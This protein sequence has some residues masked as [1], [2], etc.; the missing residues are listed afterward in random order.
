MSVLLEIDTVPSNTDIFIARNGTDYERFETER[1]MA[2]Y[3][4]WTCEASVEPGVSRIRI[5][6]TSEDVWHFFWT[7]SDNGEHSYSPIGDGKD[8]NCCEVVVPY[9]V[10]N[11]TNLY[12]EG[13]SVQS[14]YEM[15]GRDIFFTKDCAMLPLEKSMFSVC[16]YKNP[17]CYR[18]GASSDSF[19]EKAQTIEYY[20]TYTEL[21]DKT[22]AIFENE[23][24]VLERIQRM[25]GYSRLQTVECMEERERIVRETGRKFLVVCRFF[26]DFIERN[27]VTRI[28]PFRSYAGLLEA[29]DL[30]ERFMEDE[31]GAITMEAVI[32]IGLSDQKQPIRNLVRMFLYDHPVKEKT[33]L[34]RLVILIYA[35]EEIIRF[36]V[37]RGDWNSEEQSLSVFYSGMFD[38]VEMSEMK[39]TDEVLSSIRKENT[40]K[41]YLRSVIYPLILQKFENLI[42]VMEDIRSDA[43]KRIWERLKKIPPISDDVRV[44]GQSKHV[45]ENEE[46]IKMIIKDALR[47]YQSCALHL[48][49]PMWIFGSDLYWDVL[50]DYLKMFQEDF[51]L[52]QM[53][54]MM[55]TI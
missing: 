27:Y 37:S 4:D 32:A 17:G 12:L 24:H 30:I 46:P 51:E 9:T 33:G 42:F 16:S 20:L 45:L 11:G 5:V 54:Q 29:Y 18:A 6:N 52:Y 39:K 1:D 28:K 43:W 47:Q 48:Y 2:D 40:Y 15:D 19:E 31:L 26:R 23:P 35:L 38:N 8:C 21:M 14:E 25:V 7:F 36:Q 10:T 34:K 53:K 44:I 50:Y 55:R 13:V 22:N 49:H 3:D 41:W